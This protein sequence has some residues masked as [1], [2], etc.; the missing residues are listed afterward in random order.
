MIFWHGRIEQQIVDDPTTIHNA[1]KL[2]SRGFESVDFLQFFL[3]KLSREKKWNNYGLFFGG[4]GK[5]IITY[6]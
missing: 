3:C 5:I 2:L 6:C 1:Q 4:R